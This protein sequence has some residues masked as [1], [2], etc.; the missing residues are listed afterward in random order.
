MK[1]GNLKRA[2]VSEVCQRQAIG[3]GV[4][5]KLRHVL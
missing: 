3:R 5:C 2:G 4:K 1:G